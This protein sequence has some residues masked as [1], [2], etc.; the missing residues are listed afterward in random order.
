MSPGAVGRLFGKLGLKTCCLLSLGQKRPV[1]KSED[2]LKVAQ[3]AEVDG[4]CLLKAK[5][6]TRSS[7]R[8][9]P[10]SILLES[11][12]VDR[13]SPTAE[14]SALG[15]EPGFSGQVIRIALTL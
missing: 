8:T 4:G 9:V 7:H 2:I 12:P 3:I 6:K 14:I 5:G 1:G 13:T 10:G 11:R 15:D